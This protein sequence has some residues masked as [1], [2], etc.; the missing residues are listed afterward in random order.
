MFELGSTFIGQRSDTSHSWFELLFFFRFFYFYFYFYKW[1]H[2]LSSSWHLSR[3]DWTGLPDWCTVQYSDM[4][5]D[6]RASFDV[7]SIPEPHLALLA[8][9][10]YSATQIWREGGSGIQNAEDVNRYWSTSNYTLRAEIQYSPRRTAK[11]YR[12]T[13]ALKGYKQQCPM[14][15]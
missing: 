11:Q 13:V 4:E 3:I 7:E 12:Q 9:V 6:R 14:Y 8:Y 10:S 5:G 1:K 2:W 15:S